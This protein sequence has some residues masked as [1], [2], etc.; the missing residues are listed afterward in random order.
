LSKRRAEAV[1]AVLAVSGD[2]GCSRERLMALLWPEGNES[3][4]SHGLRDA[5]HAIRRTLGPAA[6]PAGGRLLRLDS[7]AITSDAQSYI[8]ALNAGRLADAVRLY[9]GPLLQGFHVDDA[10]EFERWVDGERA[11]LAREY[12]EALKQLASAAEQ[13]GAWDEAAGW[14]ARAVEHDPLNSHLVSQQ[15]RAL[16]AMGDRAN[17]VKV[18]EAHARRLRAEL[19]LDPDPEFL[20]RIE[21]IRRGDSPLP[22]ET[23]P[24]VAP[25]PV[26]AAPATRDSQDA[27]RSTPQFEPGSDLKKRV[28]RWGRWAAGVGLMVLLARTVA[29]RPPRTDERMAGWLRTEVAVLPFRNLS[30]DTAYA[31][32]AGGLHD[33]LVTQLSKVASLK[34]VGRISSQG[35]EGTTKSLRQIGEE[36]EVGSVVEASVQVVG[37][38]LRVVVQLVDPVTQAPLWAERYD[39]MLD[40]AFEVQS[41]IARQIVAAVG[42]TLTKEEARG[43]AAIPTR[44]AEAYAF[45]LQGLEYE[46]RPGGQRENLRIAGELYQR[47]LALDAD[48]ALAHAALSQVHVGMYGLRYDQVPARL[49]QAQHEADAAL[50]LVP[51]L[52]EAHLASGMRHRFL[53]SYREAL[54]EFRLALRGAPNDARVWAWIGRVQRNLGKWDSSIAAF[55]H[56]RMLDPRDTDLLH[57][58]GDT[59]HYLRRYREAIQSYRQ[60][61]ALAPDRVQTRL[62]LAWSYILWKGELDTLRTVLRGLPLQADPGS[63]GEPIGNQRLILL[64]WERRP[65]SLLSLLRVLHPEASLRRTFW[66]VE[67]LGLRGDT[68]G[69]RDRFESALAMLE[70]QQTGPDDPALHI[71][72]GLAL[73]ALGRRAEAL[74]EVSWLERADA[75]SQDRYFTGFGFNRARILARIGETDSALVLIESLLDRPSLLS[76]H[77]LRLSPDFD[78]LRSHPRYQALLQ[79]YAPA[80]TLP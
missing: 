72:R 50:R 42:A 37:R 4:A 2:L 5:L 13:A 6:V 30:A 10:P 70:R 32:F 21:R 28:V 18:A 74:R 78:P 49:V 25:R 48:F 43:I 75:A 60:A 63:G 62:S 64:L 33:E 34:V 52:P 56:A 27:A 36:L 14:W 51:G 67:A 41:D 26:E 35:Y 55:D 65:D 47:A 58:I 16:A 29:G 80:G 59:Y 9:S 54:E 71:Q 45:Y 17:A 73:A 77:Q 40:D 1:L 46:R 3:Q 23:R 7:A 15:A 20:A 22:V 69:V 38:R 24:S 19:E 39:R 57:S 61:L 79:K 44:N 68:G 11:R 76:V 8:E 12:V 31:F 66:E 53:G